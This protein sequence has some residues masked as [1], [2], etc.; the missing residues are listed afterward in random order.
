MMRKWE[1]QPNKSHLEQHNLVLT[2]FDMQQ[3]QQQSN[4]I[5][6]SRIHVWQS[7]QMNTMMM[8]WIVI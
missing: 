4:N 8:S 1:M 2:S 3:Q 6:K 7:S 5:W